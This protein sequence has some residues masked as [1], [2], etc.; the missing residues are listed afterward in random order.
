VLEGTYHPGDTV[1]IGVKGKDLHF[2]RI[3]GKGIAASA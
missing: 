1:E 2:A 3:A